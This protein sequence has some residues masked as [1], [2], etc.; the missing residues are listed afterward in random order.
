MP[1]R[2][3]SSKCFS[4]SP[5]DSEPWWVVTK[6]RSVYAPF[7]PLGEYIVVKSD[8]PTTDSAIYRPN[9]TRGTANSRQI[10]KTMWNVNG[11]WSMPP[12]NAERNAQREAESQKRITEDRKQKSRVC[13][14]LIFQSRVRRNPI[15]KQLGR[16]ATDVRNN[17][18]QSHGLPET[19]SSLFFPRF[20]S[21]FSWL[22]KAN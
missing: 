11:V 3:L 9:L 1:C 5:T 20:F 15:T 6:S 4:S 22:F 7:K 17:R 18:I 13:D 19:M 10:L 21:F 16:V 2:N 12:R 8:A 14:Q